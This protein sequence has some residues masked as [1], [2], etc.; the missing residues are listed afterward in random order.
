MHCRALNIVSVTVLFFTAHSLGTCPAAIVTYHS[1]PDWQA[2]VG[3]AAQATVFHFDGPTELY[4]KSVND[5]TI[6]P[7]YSSQGVDFLPFTGT[8]IFPQ[9]LRGQ[10]FQIPDPNR[11]GLLANNSS[12]NP[13][14]DLDGR[15]IKF[16]FNIPAMSVGVLTNRNAD[17]DGGYLEAFDAT[18]NLIGRVDLEPGIFGGIVSDQVISRVAIVNTFNSD[19]NFGVWDLQFS[20]NGIVPEPAS[21]SLNGIGF[22]CLALYMAARRR[23]RWRSSVAMEGS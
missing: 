3:G 23:L 20:R 7:S 11:D 12:P 1:Q 17:G 21:T 19:I 22:L 8:N 10:S 5:P 16:N 13:V 15:A 4:G 6:V 2:A 9:I 18:M 14:T